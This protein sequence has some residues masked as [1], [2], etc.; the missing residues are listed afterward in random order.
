MRADQKY[1]KIK[2]LLIKVLRMKPDHLQTIRIILDGTSHPGNIGAAARAMKTMGL[3]NLV[4][5][6]PKTS[7]D[8]VAYARASGATDILDNA[9]IVDSIDCALEDIQLVFATSARPRHISLPIHNAKQAATS[10][11]QA[12]ESNTRVAILF[13]NE[14]HGLSNEALQK[15]Q[16]HIVI[17]SNPVYGS[18][19]LGSAVQIIAYELFA[20]TD[21]TQENNAHI[22]LATQSA[23]TALLDH[24]VDT[25]HRIDFIKKERSAKVSQKIQVLLN[26]IPFTHTDTQI[27]RGILTEINKRLKS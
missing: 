20:Y 6:N 22:N 2:P 25:L 18:L 13:G 3:S 12:L 7:L 27:I 1:A 24:L 8:S 16:R 15:A 5:V 14:Q 11:H 19:N 10:I 9:Q 17:P 23:R 26:K 21:D 4:L